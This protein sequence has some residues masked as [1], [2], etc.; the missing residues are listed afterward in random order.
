MNSDS[1]KT[2][3]ATFAGQMKERWSA[4]TDNDL[5]DIAGRKGPLIGKLQERYAYGQE[6]AE[7]EADEFLLVH[8]SLNEL[9]NSATVEADQAAPSHARAEK[10]PQH[11]DDPS[12]SAASR[13]GVRYEIRALGHR[14]DQPACSPVEHTACRGGTLSLTVFAVDWSLSERLPGIH[15]KCVPN[16][17][18][19]SLGELRDN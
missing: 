19:R 5:E 3:E 6:Q 10:P 11:A 13:A 15:P 7:R 4:L 8:P 9:S 12:R 17:L 1:L 18:G 16:D 14:L 2:K